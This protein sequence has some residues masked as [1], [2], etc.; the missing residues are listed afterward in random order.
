[1]AKIDP[2]LSAAFEAMQTAK[3]YANATFQEAG[4]RA[5]FMERTRTYIGQ[6]PRDGKEILGPTRSS[7]T[8]KPVTRR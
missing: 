5:A 7:P 6:M 1:M 3:L 2:G 8:R 4:A